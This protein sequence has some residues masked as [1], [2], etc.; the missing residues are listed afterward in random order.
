MT[1]SVAAE[2]AGDTARLLLVSAVY[3]VR[4]AAFPCRQLV[5]HFL[6]YSFCHALRVTGDAFCTAASSHFQVEPL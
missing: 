2:R 4:S 1:T 6:H 3:L 5:E